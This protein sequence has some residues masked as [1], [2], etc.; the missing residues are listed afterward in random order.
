MKRL[1]F[2]GGILLFS[3][4]SYAQNKAIQ[5]L[6]YNDDNAAL[7]NDTSDINYHRNIKLIDLGRKGTENNLFFG[8]EA[9]IQYWDAQGINFGNLPEDRSEDES[10]FLQRFMIHSDLKLSNHVN[11]YFIVNLIA[12]R[13]GRF[14]RNL[15]CKGTYKF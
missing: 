1:L 8:G 10:Y 11:I 14:M 15:S 2:S 4:L 3:F 6:R 9:L 13:K 5:I 7:K 12:P